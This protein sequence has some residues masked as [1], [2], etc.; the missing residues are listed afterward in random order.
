MISNNKIVWIFDVDGVLTNP[1]EKRTTQKGLIEAIAKKIDDGDIITLN[2]GRSISWVENRILSPLIKEIKNKEKLVDLFIVGEKGG[3]WAFFENN[4][5]ITKIDETC[6]LPYSL[7]EE[8]KRLTN[9]EFSDSMFYDDSKITLISIEMLDGFEIDDYTKRQA[10]LIQK[11][12]E[13]REKAEYKPL[14]IRI[15]KTIVAIDVQ[16]SFT[17]KHLGARRI[18]AWIKD[19]NINPSKIIMIGD[20]QADTEMAE[21]LQHKYNVDF[22][23]VGD[24]SNLDT[25]KL[26]SKPIFT[27]NRFEKGTMEFLTSLQ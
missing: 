16:A 9:Q 8:L 12:N 2:T 20:S 18:E 26:K 25:K 27:K 11:L 24:P 14:K 3:T 22:I 1:R 17:G 10:V 13:I 19:K 4:K 5:L 21:E 23:F 7:R 6:K 15:D